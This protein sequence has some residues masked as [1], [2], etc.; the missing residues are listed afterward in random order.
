[1]GADVADTGMGTTTITE[2]VA[3]CLE[4]D[5]PAD[6]PLPVVLIVGP[7]G[8]GK[9]TLLDRLDDSLSESRPRAR[10]DLGCPGTDRDPV[11]IMARLSS[12]LHRR[13]A[14]VGTI[15]FPLF[16]LGLL[17]LDLDQSGTQI[18]R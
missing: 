5:T 14:Y 9:T 18:G 3:A 1:M 6:R 10:V 13:V 8:T 15:G 2:F 16:G 11:E 17:A 12:Q 7:R 4:R